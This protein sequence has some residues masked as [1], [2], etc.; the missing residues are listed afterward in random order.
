MSLD[1][2]K[3]YEN[4]WK[5]SSRYVLVTVEN[6]PYQTL[7]HYVD[8]GYVIYKKLSLGYAVVALLPEAVKF[9]IE[10]MIEAGVEI[11]NQPLDDNAGLE[12]L[13]TDKLDEFVLVQE[14]ANSYGI[15]HKGYKEDLIIGGISEKEHQKIIENMIQAGVEIWDKYPEIDTSQEDNK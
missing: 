10:K 6:T 8:A 14:A 15:Y 13:W 5:N 9:V 7:A 11:R 4:L 2:L 1:N 12:H 3:S